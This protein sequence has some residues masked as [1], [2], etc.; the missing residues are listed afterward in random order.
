M[1]EFSDAKSLFMR[2]PFVEINFVTFVQM[3]PKA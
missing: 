1:E 3:T 2:I